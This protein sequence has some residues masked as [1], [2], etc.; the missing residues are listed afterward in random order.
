MRDQRVGMRNHH[1]VRLKFQPK[2]MNN[3]IKRRKMPR[4]PCGLGLGLGG[5]S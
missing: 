1:G 2:N 4:H 5:V 3:V